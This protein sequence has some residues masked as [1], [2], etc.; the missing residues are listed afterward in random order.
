MS[1]KV[2]LADDHTLVRQAIAKVLQDEKS[3][4]ITGEAENG[5]KAMEL[6]RN[7]SPDVVIMDIGMP[8][9]NGIDAT[10]QIVTEFPKTKVIA[11]S[12][13]SD[14][15][16]VQQMLGAGASGYLLKDSLFDDLIEAIKSVHANK[17]YISKN[18]AHIVIDGYMRK[19]SG[20]EDKAEVVLT[21]R[22]REVLQLL[23]E[24][25]TSREIAAVLY[26]SHKTV[27]NHRKRIMNKLDLHNIA[28][29]TKY[30]I[31]HGLTSV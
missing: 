6:V 29:L 16:Y 24:G 20:E 13:H 26:I 27:E 28:E 19:D 30:A 17:G 11:L 7:L 31:R 1:I 18:I 2:I 3:I 5:R 8:E 25:K 14:K 21:N 12:Q 23:A 4:E 10:R 9:L 22:E 15:R